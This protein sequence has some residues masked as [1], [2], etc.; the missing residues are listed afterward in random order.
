MKDYIFQARNLFLKGIEYEESRK[1][2]E[3]I[4]FYKR[5]V[6]LVP[7]IELRLYESTKVKSNDDGD[8]QLEDDVSS[9]NDNTENYNEEEEEETDLFVKLCKIVNRNKC[10]CFPKFE[11][12]VS[13]RVECYT[14]IDKNIILYLFLYYVV[15]EHP[16]TH[17]RAF[18]IS[19]NSYFCFAYGNNALYIKMGCFFRVRLEI[20]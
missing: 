7:D 16:D 13:M 8:K 12:D 10:V 5:A 15:V 6:M 18:I 19:G 2:Y 11:Q 3:A 17:F 14:I 9:I 1:F 20:S 4:Q